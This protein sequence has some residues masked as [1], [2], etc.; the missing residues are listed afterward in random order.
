MQRLEFCTPEEAKAQRAQADQ[1]TR[2]DRTRKNQ[3]KTGICDHQDRV[4]LK[5]ELKEVWD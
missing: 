4:Y 5:Q 1:E 2:K 3:I